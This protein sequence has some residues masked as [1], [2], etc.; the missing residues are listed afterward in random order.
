MKQNIEIGES[1]YDFFREYDGMFYSGIVRDI[2]ELG[3]RMYDLNYG[4]V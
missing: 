2:N 4:Q 1:G 3:I